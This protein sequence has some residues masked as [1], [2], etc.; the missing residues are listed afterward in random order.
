VRK[1]Y[2]AETSLPFESS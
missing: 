1:G 2:K